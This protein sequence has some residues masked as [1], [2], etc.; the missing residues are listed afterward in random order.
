LLAVN[1]GHAIPEFT[2]FPKITVLE[3]TF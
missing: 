2:V 3:E 1:S